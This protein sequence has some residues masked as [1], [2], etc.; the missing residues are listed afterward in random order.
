[1]YKLWLAWYGYVTVLY[2]C[3]Y[4]NNID[5]IYAYMCTCV[6]GCI[7]AYRACVYDQFITYVFT[8]SPQFSVL[9]RYQP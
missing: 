4:K 2:I 5:G 7:Y 9:D 1:M 6:H 8:N 3:M